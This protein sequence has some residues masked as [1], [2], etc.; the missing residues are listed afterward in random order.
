MSKDGFLS[1]TQADLQNTLYEVN[2]KMEEEET[3]ARAATLGLPYIDLHNF[4]VDLNVLGMFTEEEAK[5]CGAVPF[6]KELADLRIGVT[7]PR[8]ALLLEKVREFSAKNQV[9]LYLISKRSLAQT[10]QFYRKVLRPKSMHDEVVRV[11]KDVDY[12]AEF[13][14]LA[15]E[16]EQQKRTATDLLALVFGAGLFYQASDIHLEPEEHIFK[17]RFR[18]DGVLQDM[19]HFAKA[20][21]QPLTSRLKIVSKLKLNVENMPQDGRMTFYYLPRLIDHWWRSSRTEHKY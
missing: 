18:V 4:P 9:K 17:L 10:M 15:Q 20:L 8:H 21:Q 14:V 11:E 2:R 1:G 3:R 12:P 5:E 16:Q 13:E 6:Y 7:D 19:L